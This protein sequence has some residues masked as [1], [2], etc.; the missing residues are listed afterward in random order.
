M[1]IMSNIDPA[2]L[3]YIHRK[4]DEVISGNRPP[5][6]DH[7]WIVRTTAGDRLYALEL[8]R[9]HT[10]GKERCQADIKKVIEVVQRPLT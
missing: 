7:D 6:V 4:V 8:L 2:K 10:Y 5:G 3:A 9:W 1:S